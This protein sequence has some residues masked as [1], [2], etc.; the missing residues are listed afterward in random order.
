[1]INLGPVHSET[2]QAAYVKD[3]E[4][5]AQA[6]RDDINHYEETGEFR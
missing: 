2:D 3:V 5:L 1:M 6:V 4:Y